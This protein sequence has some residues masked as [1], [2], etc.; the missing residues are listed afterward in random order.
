MV[1]QNHL[2]WYHHRNRLYI[3]VLLGFALAGVIGF[4]I[5]GIKH[6]GNV[7]CGKLASEV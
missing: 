4:K 1:K 6:C 5:G 7:K 2:V 3:N